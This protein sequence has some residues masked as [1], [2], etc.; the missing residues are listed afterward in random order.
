MT[1]PGDPI[2]ALPTIQIVSMTNDL[3]A[4]LR[5]IE[6]FG[7]GHLTVSQLLDSVEGLAGELAD[8]FPSGA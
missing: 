2:A 5:V 7:L 4:M 3:R 6:T 1:N 8:E